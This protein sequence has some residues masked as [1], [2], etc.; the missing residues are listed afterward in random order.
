MP[1]KPASGQ[2][3][4][5]IASGRFVITAFE[6]LGPGRIEAVYVAEEIAGDLV[7][8]GQVRFSR[9]S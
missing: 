1:A 3:E 8:A 6:E 7:P 9:H 5:A 2:L 4:K